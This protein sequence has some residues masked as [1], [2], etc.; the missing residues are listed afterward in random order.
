MGAP[1]LTLN[2][3]DS[4]VLGF[5]HLPTPGWARS[6][7]EA[8]PPQFVLPRFTKPLTSTHGLREGPEEVA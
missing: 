2:W 3:K 6:L 4:A 1:S 7:P 8:P 5:A